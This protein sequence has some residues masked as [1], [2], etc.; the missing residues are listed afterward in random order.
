MEQILKA[1][2]FTSD[3]INENSKMPEKTPIL[4]GPQHPWSSVLVHSPR[5]Q[6]TAKRLCPWRMLS[7][8]KKYWKNQ[9]PVLR[10]FTQRRAEQG[11]FHQNAFSKE[12]TCEGGGIDVFMQ[13]FTEKKKNPLR[14]IAS[15]CLDKHTHTFWQMVQSWH[16]ISLSCE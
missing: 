8:T 9:A 11:I 14:V 7:P 12:I 1:W 15:C 3:Y 2:P 13:F 16:V 4:Q 5:G 10:E 6:Y